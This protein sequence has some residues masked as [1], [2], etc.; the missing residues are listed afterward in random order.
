MKL[1]LN[2]MLLQLKIQ[3]QYK[4]SFFLTVIGQFITAFTLFF[5][6]S[7][8]FQ[9]VEAIEGF[10]Y[11]QTLLCFAVI[12]ASFALGEMAGGGLM[13]FSQKLGNGEFDRAMVRPRSV[14]M[15]IVIPNMDFT[16]LGLIIQSAVVLAI[17]IPISGVLWNG[18]KI[19]VLCFMLLCGSLLFFGLFL[20]Q[21]ACSFFTV[22]NLNC[23]NLFTYGARQF[24]KYPFSVYGKEVLW[25]LT[26][27]I[28]LA[29]FQYY[30]LLFL[31]DREGSEFYRLYPL[32]SLLFVIPCYAV[33]R[34]GMRRYKS[35]GS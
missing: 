14:L 31:L 28:P 16:R 34:F 25:L 8:I 17:A 35:T 12:M 30:P 4:I 18:E 26:Y 1:Y 27:I 6:I 10:T 15:Q 33:F 23:M 29:L 22:A 5:G 11:G 7:F 3:M 2:L 24:G 9:K 19:T 32:F 13:T 20:L 21:A